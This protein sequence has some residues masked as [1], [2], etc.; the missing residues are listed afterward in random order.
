MWNW[1]K[2]IF[3]AV[4]SFYSRTGLDKFLGQ[5]IQVAIEVLSELALV[6][7]NKAFHEW[8]DQ[9][10]D[11][12]KN[13]IGRPVADNWIALLIGFAFENLKANQT[14]NKSEIK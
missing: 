7:S 14:G 10:F 5:Y 6:N 2:R 11:A 9:A 4:K 1:I 13:R 8:K 12:L 3:G